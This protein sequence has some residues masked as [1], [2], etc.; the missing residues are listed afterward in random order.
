MFS[1]LL[2]IYLEVEL[3]GQMVI[4]YLTF[5]THATLFSKVAVQ[6]SIPTSSVW[7]FWFLHIFIN[8][9]YYSLNT[10]FQ[11]TREKQQITHKGIPIRLSAD[12]SAETLQARRE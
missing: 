5:W 4:L 1:L 9:S 7:E 10:A 6:F 3:L 8:T 12:F 2:D 11:T